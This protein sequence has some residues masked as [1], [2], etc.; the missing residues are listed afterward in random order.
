MMGVLILIQ[1]EKVFYHNLTGVY[2]INERMKFEKVQ[3]F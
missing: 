3:G 2:S 1:R